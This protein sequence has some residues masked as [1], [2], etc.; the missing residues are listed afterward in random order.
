[1]AYHVALTSI[2]FRWSI[3]RSFTTLAFWSL[4]TLKNR[5][6]KEQR[7]FQ[8]A[9]TGNSSINHQ[10]GTNLRDHWWHQ[11]PP[12]MGSNDPPQPLFLQFHSSLLWLYVCIDYRFWWIWVQILTLSI[13][14]FRWWPSPSH[15]SFSI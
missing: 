1:M 3:S 10:Q 2:V 4:R 7:R 11:W 13:L 6:K 12:L 14:S 8:W 5:T 9:T 15:L